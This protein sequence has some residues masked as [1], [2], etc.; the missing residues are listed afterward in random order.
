MFVVGGF[1]AYPPEIE[2]VLGRYPG[3]AQVAVIGIADARMG[4]VGMAWIVP[5]AG[6]EIDPEA[7]VA[8]CRHEM[9]NYKVPRRV[10]IVDAFPL[11][12]SGKVLKFELRQRAGRAASEPQ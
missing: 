3:V 11:N 10:A 7:V 4:E 9:A 1:N 2:A 6:A 5:K 8:W 12:A